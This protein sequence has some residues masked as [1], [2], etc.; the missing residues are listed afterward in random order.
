ME[1]ETKLI[2]ERMYFPV[3]FILLQSLSAYIYRNDYSYYSEKWMNL[4]F[5]MFH[6]VPLFII[7][8]C[9]LQFAFS[10]KKKSVSLI[11]VAII[12]SLLLF[13]FASILPPSVVLAYIIFAIAFITITLVLAVLIKGMKRKNEVSKDLLHVFYVGVSIFYF[14][15]TIIDTYSLPLIG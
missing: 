10:N 11:C 12:I 7:S 5:A 6:I 15:S 13:V 1:K 9:L 3:I 4:S 8:I 2:K 14:L